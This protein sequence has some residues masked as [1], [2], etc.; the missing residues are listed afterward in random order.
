MS[1]RQNL[2]EKS[3]ECETLQTAMF[4]AQGELADLTA[5]VRTGAFIVGT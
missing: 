4:K 3:I 5:T 2:R 1:L